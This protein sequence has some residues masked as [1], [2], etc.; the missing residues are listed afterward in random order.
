RPSFELEHAEIILDESFDASSIS[1]AGISSGRF[2][3]QTVSVGVVGQSNNPVTSTEIDWDTTT[4]VAQ[5]ILDSTAVRSG[6]NQITVRTM[7]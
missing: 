3:S 2:E 7:D 6:K 1:I 5:L 4:N